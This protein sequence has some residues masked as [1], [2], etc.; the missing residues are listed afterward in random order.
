MTRAQDLISPA[1]LETQRA[2]HATPRGYGGKGSKWVDV[3][4]ALAAQ[5]DAMS[6]LDYGCGQ[7]TLATAIRAKHPALVCREYDPAIPGKNAL[8]SF[9][10]LVV[11]TDVLEHIEPDRL[12]TVLDHMRSLARKAVFVVVA[13]RLASKTL[14][15]GRNAHLIVEPGGWWHART[16][17][18]GFT[19][20]PD[21]AIRPGKPAR[22]WVAVLLP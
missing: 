14:A 17:A 21:V 1:Y 20:I 19:V 22:E 12:D 5:Y 16:Q 2:L 10:D 6:V 7:G 13:T 4:A 9:A 3:V 18:R 8:P 11:S 15:D